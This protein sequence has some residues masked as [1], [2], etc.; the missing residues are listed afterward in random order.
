MNKVLVLLF[1][2]LAVV[3]SAFAA[4][5]TQEIGCIDGVQ[6]QPPG[7]PTDDYQAIVAR[8]AQLVSDFWLVSFPQHFD[9]TYDPPCHVVEYIPAT[10]PFTE[11]C[12]LTS[13]IARGNAFY[14]IPINSVLWDGPNLYHPLYEDLGRQSLVYIIAHEYAH[15]AQFQ[16]DRVAVR[17]VNLE[18]QADCYAGAYLQHAMGIGEFS[19]EEAQQVIEVV[20]MVG[21]SRLGTRWTDR[22]HGTSLQRQLAV[23]RG[24]EGGIASCNVDFETLTTEGVER[25][26]PDIQ[27]GETVITGPRGNEATITVEEAEDGNVTITGPGGRE[28]GGGE[29]RGPNR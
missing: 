4:P 19:E 1:L 2:L 17:T 27:E 10:V 16:R 23:R 3:G 22:T 20:Q 7:A 12:G 5:P 28:V 21:Q 18:L 15:S 25:P 9:G 13:D 6:F 29:R 26:A 11:E 14:C 24:F 8:D